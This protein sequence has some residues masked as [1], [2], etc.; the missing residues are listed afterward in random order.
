MVIVC[1]YKVSQHIF[2]STM[3]LRQTFSLISMI[4]LV[5]SVLLILFVDTKGQIVETNYG[6]LQGVMRQS[7]NGRNFH[8]FGKIPFAKPPVQNLRFEVG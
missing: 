7:R 2:V 1:V 5:L 8:F 4:V 6:K 3:A